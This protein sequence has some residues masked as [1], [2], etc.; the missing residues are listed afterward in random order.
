M[1]FMPLVKFREAAFVEGCAPTPEYLRRMLA[2]G[3]IVGFRD[4]NGRYWVDYDATMQRWSGCAADDD[5]I[6][7]EIRKSA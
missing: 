1:A 6:L 2:A 3:D 7:A 5:P 4:S